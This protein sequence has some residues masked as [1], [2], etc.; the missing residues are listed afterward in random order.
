MRSAAAFISTLVVLAAP[1]G[2]AEFAASSQPHTYTWPQGKGSARITIPATSTS[3]AV[4]RVES[5]R[6]KVRGKPL[7]YAAVSIDNTHS[8]TGYRLGWIDIVTNTGATIHMDKVWGAIGDWPDVSNRGLYN[9]CKV[10][11]YNSF[12]TP[13]NLLPGAR[14]TTLLATPSTVTETKERRKPV[15]NNL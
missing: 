8:P 10:D 1:A 13:D 2:A 7:T 12:L 11:L 5:C 9:R 15:L 3:L 14:S 4:R 6:Q